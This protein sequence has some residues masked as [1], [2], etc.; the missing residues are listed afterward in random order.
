MD[1][2]KKAFKA[3]FE[4]GASK[5]K[6]EAA[7][8]RHT[9]DIIGGVFGKDRW[10]ELMDITGGRLFHVSDAG[11]STNILEPGGASVRQQM[12]GGQAAEE[13]ARR[14]DQVARV[15]GEE[16]Q[17]YTSQAGMGQDVSG[18]GGR[19]ANPDDLV[20]EADP[21]SMTRGY[22]EPE[23][24]SNLFFS[25]DPLT[26]RSWSRTGGG[27][28]N[29]WP[30]RATLDEGD[31]DPRLLKTDPEDLDAGSDLRYA[32]PMRYPEGVGV[33]GKEPVPAGELDVDFDEA[34]DFVAEVL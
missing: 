8:G 17:R 6:K 12:R 28:G 31:I 26:Y 29:I 1:K 9:E 11:K 24:Q 10:N 20:E 7:L 14:G 25:V 33:R 34:R 15:Q 2:I 19:R 27:S 5:T 21:T 4:K 30:V 18:A 23:R 16:M 3:G 22:N 13:A 32:L